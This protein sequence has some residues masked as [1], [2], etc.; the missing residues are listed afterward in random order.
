MRT[1]QLDHVAVAMPRLAEALPFVVGEL[2]G[3]YVGGGDAG[4]FLW[5]QY[6]YAGGGLL[7]LLEPA[8]PE[9]GFLHRFVDHH[10]PGVHHVTFK[11]DNLEETCERAEA[12]GFSVVGYDDSDPEWM[13][14]FLH[15]K[16]A[17]GLV[18]QLASVPADV[19][20]APEPSASPPAGDPD[21]GPP[22]VGMA[23]LRTGTRDPDRAHR[24]W[25]ELLGGDATVVEDGWRVRW[26]GSPMYLSVRTAP[27]DGPLAIE[28]ECL[29]PALV[30]RGPHPVLGV[31]FDTV[32]AT[33]ADVKG[34]G[35]TRTAGEEERDAGDVY[36]LEEP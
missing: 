15:P 9:G 27:E 24:L 1:V 7:E 28:L 18:V 2:G 6:R 32:D 34:A 14:A 20:T 31:C 5:R 22:G 21:P 29:R 16:G 8:G 13:E 25:C 4:A 3:R 12:L 26:Q 17:E 33:T 23:G 19:G 10:G 36:H 30:P 11:V 35:A